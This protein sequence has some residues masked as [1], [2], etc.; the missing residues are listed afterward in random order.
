MTI[1]QWRSDPEKVKLASKLLSDPVM[2]AM[3]DTLASRSIIS[4][5][6]MGVS[7]D[8]KATILGEAIGYRN[9]LDTIRS[10]GQVLPVHT[11]PEATF[12]PDSNQE[13]Q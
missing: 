11:E 6:P 5:N 9:C 3:L 8:D 7:P 12:Q 4:V 1:T 2:L 10:M 13:E